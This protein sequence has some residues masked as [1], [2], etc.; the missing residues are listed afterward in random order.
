MLLLHHAPFY[1]RQSKDHPYCNNQDV[2]INQFSCK[3][4][5]GDKFKYILLIEKV[6]LTRLLT[7]WN[8]K[9]ELNQVFALQFFNGVSQEV[10]ITLEPRV[11]TYTMYLITF[12]S[13]SFLL[14][15][16]SRIGNTRAIATVLAVSFKSNGVDQ[17][18]KQNMQ[19][20][21]FSSIILLFNY[22]IGF[23][24][25]LFIAIHR[26]FFIE[27]FLSLILAFSI[28]FALFLI[29]FI[30]PIIVGILTGEFKKIGVSTMNTITG[31]QLFGLI[32]SLLALFWIMNPSFN[33]WFL[34]AF[35]FLVCLKSLIRLFKSSY[36]V[37]T[38]GVSWYY[39]ILSFCTLE[40]LPLFVAY[41]YA[42]SVVVRDI[43]GIACNEVVG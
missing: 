1:A 27:D 33:V 32:F 43:T 36:V 19:L 35:G 17:I 26:I 31:D 15:A 9:V 12:L 5:Y 29:E 3:Y 40:I 4:F 8:Q 18:L 2:R 11:E 24:L 14:V 10:P 38:N 6:S 28:P 39:L 41:N 16:I 22:F 34:Y 23:G 37:L 30:S 42:I 20:S 7:L 21:S 13:L 25:C